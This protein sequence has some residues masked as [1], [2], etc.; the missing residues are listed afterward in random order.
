MYIYM[1]IY[2]CIYIYVYIMYIYIM[3]IISYSFLWPFNCTHRQHKFRK[4]NSFWP[5]NLIWYADMQF[6]PT[7][8]NNYTRSI[9]MAIVL[10]ASYCTLTSSMVSRRYVESSFYFHQFR[11]AFLVKHIWTYSWTSSWYASVCV[12]EEP[13]ILGEFK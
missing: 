10:S 13:T 11:N 7:M 1:Y 6:Y 3:W 4:I 12:I 5:W 8:K 2:I 9:S